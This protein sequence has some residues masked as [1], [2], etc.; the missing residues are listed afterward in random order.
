MLAF[1]EISDSDCVM[2]ILDKKWICDLSAHRTCHIKKNASYVY[3][4]D[5]KPSHLEIPSHHLIP[6]QK[7]SENVSISTSFC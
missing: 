6:D 4:K 5:R 1:D 7:S 2:K 3:L